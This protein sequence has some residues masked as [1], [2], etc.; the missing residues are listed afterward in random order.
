MEV[1][2]PSLAVVAH[3]VL[4]VMGQLAFPFQYYDYPELLLEEYQS[5]SPAPTDKAHRDSRLASRQRDD[6][7]QWDDTEYPDPKSM[8]ERH[9]PAVLP[10]E[11]PSEGTGRLD[12]LGRHGP[13]PGLHGVAK[14]TLPERPKGEPPA[15]PV[16]L[17]AEPSHP[18]P[19]P[20]IHYPSRPDFDDSI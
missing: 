8:P 5:L 4:E 14:W 1:A 3:A 11:E 17:A 2:E 15:L 19:A 20:R 18:L 10:H 9:T 6:R 7:Y 13:I 16:Y 12:L